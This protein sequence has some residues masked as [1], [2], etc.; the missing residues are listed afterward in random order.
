LEKTSSPGAADRT[1]V[2]CG[3]DIF[4]NAKAARSSLCRPSGWLALWRRIGA[5]SVLDQ[6]FAG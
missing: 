3:A 1:T 6:G 5:F 4:T 2:A